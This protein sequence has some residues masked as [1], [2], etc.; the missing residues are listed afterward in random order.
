[1]RYATVHNVSEI[2]LSS[3]VRV[4]FLNYD[5]ALSCIFNHWSILAEEKEFH[6]GGW[7]KFWIVKIKIFMN[8]P[9]WK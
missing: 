2:S 6:C 5:N 1:M 8:S 9:V 4:I 3:S 7:G